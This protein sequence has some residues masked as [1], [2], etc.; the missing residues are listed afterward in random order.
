MMMAELNPMNS[1]IVDK[2]SAMNL[3]NLL[4]RISSWFT[5]ARRHSFMTV[6]NDRMINLANAFEYG[7][8]R[9]TVDDHN[10]R[11]F[12]RFQKRDFDWVDSL[13]LNAAREL[14]KLTET[15]ISKFDQVWKCPLEAPHPFH[16]LNGFPPSALGS[17]ATS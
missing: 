4:H 13:S 8:V 3:K 16:S 17:A 12:L 15:H 7:F 2:K 11:A 9:I 10:C 1:H 14:C 5:L 6:N